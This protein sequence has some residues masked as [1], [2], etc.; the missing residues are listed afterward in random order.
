MS[1]RTKA[2]KRALDVLYESEL[3]ADSSLGSTLAGRIDDAEP[4]LNPYTVRLVEGVVQHREEIDR[5]L[6]E[7]A[8]GW[9][10]DRMPAIDRNLL[11]LAV[12]EICY[13]DDV[14]DP[15]AVSEAV[16]LATSLSTEQS[17][18]FVNG[19]LAR[20]VREKPHLTV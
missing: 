1:A 4:P 17:P 10:L 19:L 7:H 3:R 18:T 13:L 12:F 9:T 11:R 20:I 6:A 5:L 8:V 15:V 16:T 2:R 14:P